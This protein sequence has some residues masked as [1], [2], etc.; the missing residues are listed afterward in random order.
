MTRGS[1]GPKDGGCAVPR[2]PLGGAAGKRLDAN[3][4]DAAFLHNIDRTVY[5]ASRLLRH[6]LPAARAAVNSQYAKTSFSVQAS[7]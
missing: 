4:S 1:E 5:A 6:A 3:P 2:A 7:M